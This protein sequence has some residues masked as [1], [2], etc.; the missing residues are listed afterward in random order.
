LGG[1]DTL[2]WY[3]NSPLEDEDYFWIALNERIDQKVKNHETKVGWVSGVIGLAI[4]LG[5][6]HAF[7]IL[8][9]AETC[10]NKGG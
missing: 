5:I 10:S 6:F 2:G 4:L 1:F 8:R 9:T 3:I 7:W